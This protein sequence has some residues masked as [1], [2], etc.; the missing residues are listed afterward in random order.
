MKRNNTLYCGNCGKPGHI[1]KK[2][3]EPITSMGVIIYKHNNETNEKN[4]LMIR[5]RNTLGFVEFMRGKYT[6]DNYK[7]I[8]NIFTIMTI[9]EREMIL[10]NSFD[11]LWDKLWMN[12]NLKQYHSEYSHSKKKYEILSSGLI[13]TS[14]NQKLT[15]QDFHRMADRNYTEQEWGFPK[16]RR[17][18]KENDLEAAKR[19]C[20]EETGLTESDYRVCED[21]PK[22]EEVFLGTNNIRYKHI[23]FLAEFTSDKK[24]GVDLNNKTQV[25]EISSVNWFSKDQCLKKIR[26]YNEE[27]KILIKKVDEYLSNINISRNNESKI[28]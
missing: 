7:Y 4:Y 14:L 24:L 9:H 6:L 19:E 21:Y 28:I 3:M 22:F 23:Y 16:G 20:N 13:V 18:L 10:N 26:N 2:C 25:M 8:L 15:L 1:Y 17:N 5:R 11:Y 27:K 12:R